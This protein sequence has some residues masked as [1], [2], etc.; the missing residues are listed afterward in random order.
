MT[1]RIAAC[2]GLAL[3]YGLVGCSAKSSPAP[4]QTTEA[5]TQA[6]NEKPGESY[7]HVIAAEVEYYTSGP[8]QG[9]PP[10]GKFKAGTKV[11]VI[12]EAGSYTQVRSEDGIEAFVASDAIKKID[13]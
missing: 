12:Q 10:D 4:N 3:A 13:P 9:R 2:V 11:N 8:Q 7:R 1:R 5:A 6:A